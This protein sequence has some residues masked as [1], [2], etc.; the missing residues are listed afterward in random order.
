M[1][2]IGLAISLASLYSA[3]I[4]TA[5][6]VEAYKNFRNEASQLSARFQADKA[7]LQRWAK[8]VGFSENGLSED[9][10]H[11]LDSPGIGLA[12]QEILLSLQ[13]LLEATE[14]A[15]SKTSHKGAGSL[16]SARQLAFAQDASSPISI[17]SRKRDRLAWSFGGKER[18]ATLVD[19]F[20]IF[21]GKL[22]DLVSIKTDPE[23]WSLTRQSPQVGSEG[24]FGG[25]Y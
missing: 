1:E 7:I 17:S 3:C 11:R 14:G 16:Y 6:R 4:E 5:H 13:T 18:F 10:D 21:V 23:Q 8:K 15:Q 19:T 9:Y 24:E 20:S 25:I 12:V 22:E 2:V